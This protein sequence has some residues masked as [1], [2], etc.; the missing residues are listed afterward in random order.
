LCE[1]VSP[2]SNGSRFDC[3]VVFLAVRIVEYSH[4]PTDAYFELVRCVIGLFFK[5]PTNSQ[6]HN[7][8]VRLIEALAAS[9][10]LDAVF[11]QKVDLFSLIH[12]RMLARS[13][14]VTNAYWAQIAA[15]AKI[16]SPIA[17][18]AGVD[19]TSWERDVM[20]PIRAN[21]SVIAAEYGGSLPARIG[22][23]EE[24]STNAA[25]LIA[26]GMAVAAVAFGYILIRRRRWWK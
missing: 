7:G 12:D 1:Q 8:L 6:I 21:D 23:D 20:D 25:L 17:R 26:A 4:S 14:E 5:L 10:R 24:G 13:T 18:Q 15:I 9:G 2:D 22:R 3:A 16:I 11:L 19:V